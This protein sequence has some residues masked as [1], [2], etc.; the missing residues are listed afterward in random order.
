MIKRI[1][2]SFLVFFV[3]LQFSFIFFSFNL[4]NEKTEKEMINIVMAETDVRFE[5]QVEIPGSRFRK[6]V[7][8]KL[9]KNQ[10][11]IGEYIVSIYNYAQAIAGILAAIM[12]A[13]G[14]VIWLTAGGNTSK[15]ETA[16][17]YIGGALGGLVLLFASHL[18]L[19]TINPALV[20][21]ELTMV[22]PVV[23][24]NKEYA[25]KK[26]K[27][28]AHFKTIRKSPDNPNRARKECEEYCE[29][30]NGEEFGELTKIDS[31]NPHSSITQYKCQCKFVSE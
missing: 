13:V 30:F 16:K 24:L 2:Q 28:K 7:P 1:G 11:L 6:D 14:G 12:I 3:L 19:R 21:M 4:Y 18:L 5:P 22:E 29:T 17:S 9:E 27:P 15:V 25:E 8:I 20:S 26:P 31:T 10:N 23:G